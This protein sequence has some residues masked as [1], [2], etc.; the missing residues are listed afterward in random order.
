M[1][2]VHWNLFHGILLEIVRDDLY[3]YLGLWHIL[4][5]GVIDDA[6]V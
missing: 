3:I 4:Y 2:S 1:I 5:E 6:Y